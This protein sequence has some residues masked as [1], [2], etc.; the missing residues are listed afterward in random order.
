MDDQVQALLLCVEMLCF[1]CC[2]DKV[3]SV[4]SLFGNLLAIDSKIYNTNVA[5]MVRHVCC[6]DYA[7]HSFP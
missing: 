7:N 1:I 2:I 4:I 5:H 3:M 6:K